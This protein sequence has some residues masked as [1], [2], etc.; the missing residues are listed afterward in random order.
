MSFLI[1]LVIFSISSEEYSHQHCH[2]V[3]N[4]FD[5]TL[6]VASE[7]T[8]EILERL[9]KGA[10]KLSRERKKYFFILVFKFKGNEKISL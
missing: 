1:N 5:A 10:Q 4:I 3:A 9:D 8:N 7:D 6:I 2:R